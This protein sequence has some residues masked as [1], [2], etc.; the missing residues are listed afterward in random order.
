MD[1]EIKKS[2]EQVLISM[3]GSLDTIAAVKAESLIEDMEEMATLP[4]VI[5]C[6][7][8]DYISS[9]G[10]RLLLRIRKMVGASGQMVTLLNANANIKEVLAITHFDKIFVMKP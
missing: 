8:L 3:N 5:D 10:L 2:D 7:K 1:I 9:S 6:T 4:V